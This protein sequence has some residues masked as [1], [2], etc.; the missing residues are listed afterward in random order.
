M[1]KKIQFGG[2]QNRCK[3]IVCQERRAC[4]IL[5]ML[6]ARVKGDGPCEMSN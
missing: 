2:N 1:R 4:R 6:A 5:W 3:G